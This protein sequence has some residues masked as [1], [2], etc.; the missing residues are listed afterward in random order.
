VSGDELVILLNRHFGYEVVRQSGS[1][2]RLTTPLSGEHHLTVPRS[3]S[4]R[5]GTLGAI[6]SE[7]AMHFQRPRDEVVR[8]LFGS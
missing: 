6:L 5:V 7:V 8:T 3:Q 4:L 1:H 2:V